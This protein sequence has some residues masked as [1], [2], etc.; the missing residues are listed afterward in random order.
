M[1]IW[2]NDGTNIRERDQWEYRQGRLGRLHVKH[3]QELTCDGRVIAVGK[4][5]EEATTNRHFTMHQAGCA[6]TA[7]MTR[8]ILAIIKN[9]LFNADLL[10][11]AYNWVQPS[12]V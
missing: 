5:G 2:H 10:G 3:E 7:S 1:T 6:F 8:S 9:E 12:G 11:V 4:L